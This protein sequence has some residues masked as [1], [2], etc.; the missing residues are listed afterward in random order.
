LTFILKQAASESIGT[1]KRWHR[2]IGVRE[3]DENIETVINEKKNCI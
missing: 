3:W 2:K 1:R